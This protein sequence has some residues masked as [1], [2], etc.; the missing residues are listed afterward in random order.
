[1]IL[2]KARVIC[3]FA[4]VLSGICLAPAQ[5]SEVHSSAAK[6]GSDH[7]QTATKPLTPK[8]AMPSRHKSSIAV[9]KA[10]TKSANTNAELARL[11]RQSNKA[12][13]PKS[14]SAAAAKSGSPKAYGTSAQKRDVIDFK[15]QKPVGGTQAATPSAHTPNSSTP[16]V[17]KN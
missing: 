10:G 5:N 15:Y 3:L 7:L 9:P 16:R 11:E 13:A 12:A 6:S 4:A 2:M 8:S 14:G 1:M 17:K